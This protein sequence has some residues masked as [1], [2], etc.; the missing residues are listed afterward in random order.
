[1]AAESNIMKAEDFAKVSAID[2]VSRFETNINQLM[3]LLGLTRKVE[4]QPGTVVKTY[5]VVGELADGKVGEGEVIPLSHYETEVGDI[6]EMELLK[7]RKATTLEAINDKGY[8][9]AVEDTDAAMLKDVQKGIRSNFYAFITAGEATVV[10]PS[11]QKALAAL[12]TKNQLLWEDTDASGFLYFVSPEDIGDYLGEA[13]ISTQ[14]AFGMT[15]IQGFLG[16]YD[17]VSYSGIPK[18]TVV[19]TAKENVILYYVNPKNG[20]L[21]KAFEFTVDQTGLIGVHRDVDYSNLST[22]TVMLCGVMLFA[23]MIDGL[24]KGRIEGGTPAAFSADAAPM[25][26]SVSPAELASAVATGVADAMSAAGA[27]PATAP[28]ASAG[29]EAP[30]SVDD[31]STTAQLEAYAEAHGIDLDGCNTTA[32][33]LK[34]IKAAEQAS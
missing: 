25:V 24:V 6:F 33:R 22:E 32:D 3:E 9:Q 30:A 13:A 20:E 26:A 31:R 14:T 16:I 4:K 7:F 8:E 18:G 21:A 10:A 23:E 17:V 19:T 5:K 29:A 15:Y 11:L 12:W 28:T 2:F 1:M 34:A 27:A